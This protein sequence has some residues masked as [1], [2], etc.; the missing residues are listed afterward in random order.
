MNEIRLLKGGW[1]TSLSELLGSADTEIVISSP[2]VS[3]DGA[4]F[5]LDR[6][7]PLFRENGSL[8]FVTNLSPANLVQGVTNPEA[9]H[10]MVSELPGTQVYHLPRLHAKAYISD[11]K[12][13]IVTS[14][15]L[16]FSGLMQN[17]EYGVLISDVGVVS[18]VRDDIVDYAQLG[19][20]IEQKQL[21]TY[22]T[23]I[24]GARAAFRHQQASISHTAQQLFEKAFEAAN[25]ELIRLRLAE[26]PMHAVFSRTLLFLL[27]QHGPLTT[28]ELHLF[29]EQIHPD[30]CDNALDRVIDGKRYGKKWKHAV[31]TAQQ[32]LKKKGAIVLER[33]KWRF[34]GA[35]D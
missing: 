23:A 15:N 8:I 12:R 27:E 24:E 9:L 20:R 18:R 29:I 16:T 14:G 13:A 25:D 35:S 21:M 2:F 28:E 22:C 17:Y 34:V 33:D 1:S 19:A 4:R 32:H 10:N 6:V 31:R 26:G 7:S 5:V 11:S 3:Y 30:L